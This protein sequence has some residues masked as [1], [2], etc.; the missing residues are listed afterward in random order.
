MENH[1]IIPMPGPPQLPV[2]GNIHQLNS[3]SPVQA[4]QVLAKEYGEVF[5]LKIAS[6]QLV[7]LSSQRLV[8]EVC[9]ENRFE[10]KL[11]GPLTELRALAGDGLFTAETKEKNWE[12]AH[13]ILLPAFGPVAIRG[14]FDEMLDIARQLFLKWERLGD[15]TVVDIADN[16]TRLTLDTI[17]LA[18]F[19]YRFNSF[20]QNEIHFF[21]QAMVNGLEEASARSR[22][23]E[24]ANHMLVKKKGRYDQNI[25]IMQNIADEVIAQRRAHPNPS[26][27]PDLL[28]I[29]L[30]ASDPVTGAKL[31]DVNIR[32]QLVTFLIAG[33]ETTSGLLSFAIYEL[34]RNPQVLA[35]ARA[36]IDAVIQDRAPRVED[37][38]KLV[39]LEQ[40][41]KE[42][43]RLWPTAPAFSVRCL[44]DE[45]TL[46]GTFKVYKDDTILILA[47]GLHRDAKVWEEPELFNPDRMA[48]ERFAKLPANAWKPFGNGA[49]A[50]IGRAFAMQEALLVLAMAIK[51]FDMEYA[52]PHY[53]LEIKESLTLKP[54]GLKVRLKKR[55]RDG[56][57]AETARSGELHPLETAK[58]KRSLHPSVT[59]QILYGSNSG[60]SEAFARK[61]GNEAVIRGC[62][63]SVQS[64]DEAV[65]RL[66]SAGPV[67]IVT[68]TY[69]GRP[70]DNAKAFCQWLGSLAEGALKDV[71]FAVLGCGNSD[72]T[73]TYQAIPT[74]IDEGMAK[75]GA[76][77]IMERAGADAR[78]DFFGTF[79][80]WSE[81]L[82]T[83]L[84]LGSDSH[85][86]Y[87]LIVNFVEQ[88]HEAWIRSQGLVSG[89]VLEVRD[90]VDMSRPG[91]RRKIHVTIEL[92]EGLEYKVG[93]YLNVLAQNSAANVSRTLLR[94]RL[95]GETKIVLKG[96][97]APEHLPLDREVTINDL[98]T[99]FVELAQPATRNQ[100]MRLAESAP[101]PPEKKALLALIESEEEFYSSVLLK[102]V[103]LLDLMER[104][105]SCMLSF[106]DFLKEL[107]AMRVRP[108]SIS[109]SPLRSPRICTLTV[110]V[111]QAPALSGQGDYAGVASNFLAR[112]SP[113]DTVPVMVKASKESFGLPVNPE[114]P[115]IMVGAGTGLAP[116]RGFIEERAMLQGQ[117]RAL[118]PGL[119]FFG[120]DHPEV[121]Y[122]YR[123]ELKSYEEAG[124]L[125]VRP[126]FSARVEEGIAFV[127]HRLW[128]DRREVIDLLLD[129]AHLY[130]C[131]DG[132]FMAPAVRKTLVESYAEVRK[133]SQAAAEEWVA[134]L[135]NEERYVADVF[136]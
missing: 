127:Q 90:L 43:L 123:E 69:E 60:A 15:G 133:T 3:D 121:D 124:H 14:M 78:G 93:D 33:H 25:R 6:R 125:R 99:H 128:H 40:I 37:L 29:M 96:D 73:R 66:S 119:L 26:G 46:A 45:T 53:R 63:A 84:S 42:T 70:P 64:L 91:A 9:D 88:P 58:K 101:C 105:Q 19:H 79:E 122:L 57:R 107:P 24:L 28:D 81:D 50:C 62:S 68:S 34:L 21:V 129:G 59:L 44:E 49:R 116:F 82:W 22:R 30:N 85:A 132:S 97:F 76:A 115:I 71:R 103:S 65:G 130:V 12:I 18:S 74:F 16:M 36:E 95:K 89:K 118:T 80:S 56:A 41:L 135:E 83:K 48:A 92:P 52:D 134:S 108:Y 104:Y 86:K 20:Y 94:F 35:R 98:L 8:D 77:R 39:Y 38:S 114:A 67:I 87:P 117:G 109:S 11:H 120:C 55:Q 106:G 47:P 1:S 27:K 5:R 126:A 111:V 7:V 54:H 75:A 72:W 110:A 51:D 2:L 113:G 4:L 32:H 23:P 102:R 17:A 10:K 61:L 31:D 131:G 100:I 13:R 136:S 112:L